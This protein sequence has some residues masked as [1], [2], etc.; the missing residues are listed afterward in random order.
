MF[1]NIML[2]IQMLASF[3][4]LLAI[5]AGLVCG[6]VI[7]AIPGLTAD[8]AIILCLPI[9]Y[10]MEPV[11]AILLC[12]G[13]YCG[14]TYGGSITAILINT[15]GTPANAATLLD[16]YPLAKQGKPLKAL[17]MALYAS[18]V[19]G[20]FSALVLLFAAP[21]IA[22]ITLLFGPPEYFSIAIFGLSVIAS[23]S[24]GS[25]AKG[26]IGGIL[27]IFVAIIGMDSVSGV[28]R[29]SFGIKQLSGGI[30]LI[31][32]LVGLF[33]LAE[34]LCKSTYDPATDPARRQKLTL[35]REKLTW[36]EIKR[37]VRAM[38]TSSVIGTLVGATPGTGG[39]IAA[40][41]SY[42][43]AK[44]S[45]KVG[46]NF[47][48]GEIEGIAASEAA[49]NA[50][51]GSTMIPL[52]TLGIPG[53][54][55]TAI[56]LGALMLQGMTPGPSLFINSPDIIYGIMV[57]LLVVNVLMLLIGRIFTRFY[58]NITRIPYELMSSMIII[59][60][61]AGTY[62]SASS[63]FHVLVAVCVGVASYI[64]R[65]LDFPIVP[66]ILGVVLGQMTELNFRRSMVLSEGSFSIF[67]TRPFSL[68]FISLAVLSICMAVWKA[69]R[70]KAKTAS[71][72]TD[73]AG[74]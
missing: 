58:V 32:T 13:L 43:Q 21:N 23:V 6:V 24:G 49:N 12:L 56:L 14:G 54:G 73:A 59:Y 2:G 47:G 16:G 68:I 30:P 37:C 67:L 39:G 27:G 15:P 57:G 7:G 5:L 10:S 40:F 45:S 63:T 55:V 70:K 35:D 33:A 48:K 66:I 50:T 18:F 64:L 9:T 41:I 53:D 62:S 74:Q 34:L 46:D 36:P 61:I 65:K 3:E 28:I 42:D 26:L 60:C 19:G 31:V 8:L 44:K 22:K 1:D 25:I 38:L 69:T 29:F 72:P 52:L 71:V 4:S 11:P 17:T 51:T 20:I